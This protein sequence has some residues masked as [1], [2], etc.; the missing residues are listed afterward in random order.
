MDILLY[1][2]PNCD[3]VR[4]ARKWFAAQGIGA[5]FHDFRKDGVPAALLEAWIA[6]FGW[7]ALLNKAGTTWRSLPEVERLAVRDARSACDLML[8]QP[9]LIKRPVIVHGGSVRIGFAPAD[10]SR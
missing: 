10:Y 9:A 5:G 2:I 8:R 4:A 7:E 3:K 6:E 1:G